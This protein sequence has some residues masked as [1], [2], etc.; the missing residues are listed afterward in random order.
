M[1]EMDTDSGVLDFILPADDVGEAIEQA[2]N[3]YL[4]ANNL[5][6]QSLELTEGELALETVAAS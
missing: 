1:Q 2:V 5:E 4:S 3:N 6:L